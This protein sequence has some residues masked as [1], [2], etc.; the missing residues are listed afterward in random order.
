MNIGRK[1]PLIS[2]VMPTFNRADLLEVALR[3]LAVQTLPA[4]EYEV[5]VVDDGSA[6]CTARMCRDLEGLLPLRYFRLDHAGTAAA[7]N[8]GVFVSRGTLVLILDDDDYPDQ[9]LLRAHVEGHER[10]PKEAVAVLGYTTWAPE[11][12]ITELMWYVTDIGQYLFAYR[13]LKHGQMLNFTHF[14]AGRISL[15]RAFLTQYGVFNQDMFWPSYED[16][17]LGYRLSHHGLRIAFSR[18][19][20]SYMNRSMSYDSFCLRC[21][22]QGASQWLLTSIHREPILDEYCRL[23]D[24]RTTWE[25]LR[26]DLDHNVRRV[27]EL[28]S[29]LA[30]EQS[31]SRQET[32]RNQL[33]ALYRDTFFAFRVKGYV[34]AAASVG[35]RLE[36]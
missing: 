17:E 16:V 33:H 23:P 6:D 5:V 9:D 19:A 27:H 12:T 7:K 24:P 13:D 25:R 1:D 36:A 26:H 3:K 11:L 31:E 18:D 20:V 4:N 8:L 14:W 22:A 32:F 34:E 29:A 30:D 21:E 35:V 28:E 10:H 15:K 2:V